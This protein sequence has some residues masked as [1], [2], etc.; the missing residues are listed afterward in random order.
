MRFLRIWVVVIR[1][2]DGEIGVENLVN[3]GGVGEAKWVRERKGG[4][5]KTNEVR[6]DVFG[7]VAIFEDEVL[8]EGVCG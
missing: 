5:R 1:T 3:E 8:E 7:L 4:E 6:V 2:R